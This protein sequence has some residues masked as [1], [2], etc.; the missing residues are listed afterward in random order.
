MI[1]SALDERRADAARRDSRNGRLLVVDD[2]DGVRAALARFF[3]A[4]GF[5][6]DTAESGARAL[7][8]IVP[9]RYAIA[10]CDVR[11]PQ[12]SGLELLPRLLQRDANLAVLMLSALNDPSTAGESLAL[13]AME[14]LAKPIALEEVQLAVERALHRRSSVLE[15][16]VVDGAQ[17]LPAARGAS[18]GALGRAAEGLKRLVDMFEARESCFAGMSVRVAR[19]SQ[20]LCRQLGLPEN[21]GHEIALAARLH[22]VGRLVV[23]PA[24]L[25]KPGLLTP[26]E[27]EEIQQHVPRGLEILEPL[28][29]GTPA[30]AAVRDHHEHWDGGGYPRGIAAERISLGGRV[31]S[32]ADTFVALTSRRPYREAL[33]A[34]DAWDILTARAGSVLDPRVVEA[35]RPAI[36]PGTDRGLTPA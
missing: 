30:L 7:D 13:G 3:Q 9:G 2:E 5:D 8:L 17:D 32:V 24:I 28:L 33:S 34:A 29:G 19:T 12:M 35:L 31:L 10:I 25:S 22:D 11:M 26:D 23:D 6:V 16:R 21:E 18:A 20:D 14:Y 4:R 36:E 27:F 1:D 15:Q